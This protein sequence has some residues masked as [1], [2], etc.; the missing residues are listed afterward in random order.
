MVRRDLE[1]ACA[2][3]SDPVTV[4]EELAAAFE[5]TVQRVLARLGFDTSTIAIPRLHSSVRPTRAN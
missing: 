1:S 2:M 4:Y 5:S 3:A